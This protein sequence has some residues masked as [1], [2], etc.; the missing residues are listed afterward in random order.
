MNEHSGFTLIELMIVLTIIAVLTVIAVP[1]Y[2]EQQEGARRSDGQAALMGLAQAMERQYTE[3]GT[4]AKA[5][6]DDTDES[7]VSVAPA[8]GVFAS[9][10]PLDGSI[11]YYDLRII[12]ANATGYIIQA[13]PKNVQADNGI[14][15]LTSVGVKSWDKDDSGTFATTEN[16]W[17]KV[18]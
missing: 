4:Y 15:Q 10:A 12:D 13:I 2:S 3:E 5:D 1:M 18:C 17:A 16:C 6:G 14:L 11:K 9:E 7:G 8:A